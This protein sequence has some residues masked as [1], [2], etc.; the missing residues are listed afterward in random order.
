MDSYEFV[1]FGSLIAVG[2][3]QDSIYITSDGYPDQFG[4]ERGKKYMSKRFK[5]LLCM[6]HEHS[7][8]EQKI[9]L[10]NEMNEWM[11]DA[12]EQVDDICVIGVRIK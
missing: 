11:G 4:G 10:D 7:M 8:S 1:I 9:L 6:V 5:K 2:T 3:E 12:Y